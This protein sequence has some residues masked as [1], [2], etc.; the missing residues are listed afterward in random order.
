[1][2]SPYVSYYPG[3]YSISYYDHDKQKNHPMFPYR[4][5]F[6]SR[7]Y[8][9]TSSTSPY[10]RGRLMIWGTPM[11]SKWTWI[12]WRSDPTF[13]IWVLMTKWRG[14]HHRGWDCPLCLCLCRRRI[15]HW[16]KQLPNYNPKRILPKYIISVP[17][18]Y[19]NFSAW[20]LSY[21]CS[22]SERK[23]STKIG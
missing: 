21:F 22:G 1:M 15:S 6:R 4:P 14:D 5:V 23:A 7:D 20:I 19:P 16:Q 10:I 9:P 3:I 13:M 8:F 11:T 18:P 2:W 12:L 17:N